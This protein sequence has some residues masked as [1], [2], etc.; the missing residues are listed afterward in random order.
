MQ[1]CLCNMKEDNQ[2]VRGCEAKFNLTHNHLVTLSL[3]CCPSIRIKAQCSLLFDV[4][5]VPSCS[6]RANATRERVRL[7]C[8]VGTGRGR[9][10]TSVTSILG[11]SYSI[12]RRG[13]A[14]TIAHNETWICGRAL[15]PH[16]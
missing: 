12:R 3:P 2:R 11:P 9:T 5:Q 8:G 6:S 7:S 4:E 10:T 15:R 16:A 14:A 13:T 1:Q